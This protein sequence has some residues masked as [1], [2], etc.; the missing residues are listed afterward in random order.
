MKTLLS[1]IK[2]EFYHILRDPLSLLIMF[3]FPIILM[4][5]LSYAVS[6]EVRNIPYVVMD[7]SKSQESRELIEKLN[8]NAYF[9]L[10]S[11]VNTVQEVEAAFQKGVCSMAIVIPAGFGSEPVHSGA[12]DIQVMVD[13]TDPNQASMM[14]NYFQAELMDYRQ[15]KRRT[16]GTEAVVVTEVKMLYNPQLLSAFNI[17]PGLQ[18]VVLLLICAMMTSIAVVREKELGTME[19]LLVSP[20][21][22]QVIIFAKVIPYLVVS[23]VDV[24]L[25]LVLSNVV[26]GVP[27][28]GS[29]ALLMTFSLIYIFTALSMGMLISTVAGTQQTAMVV[30]GVGLM[31]PTLLLSGLIFPIDSMPG[32]LRVLSNFVPARWFVEALRG[33]MIKGLG[34]DA[35][36]KPFFILLGMCIFFMAAGIKKFKNR[37]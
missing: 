20:L 12:S 18:G 1:F 10:K 17:V 27:V 30:V 5:I 6:T 34:F 15:A 7:M 26:L 31:L 16:A 22:P 32:I 28:N 21:K 2:K 8:G 25:I 24:A 4:T 33:V 36:W 9:R 35:V 19:I 3:L 23:I 37:L 13:A 14:V 11:N 29:I